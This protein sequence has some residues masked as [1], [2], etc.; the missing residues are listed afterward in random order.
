[1]RLQSNA[2]QKRLEGLKMLL[3]DCV[4]YALIVSGLL[5]VVLIVGGLAL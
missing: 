5:F 3:C 1:M 2:T 4:R